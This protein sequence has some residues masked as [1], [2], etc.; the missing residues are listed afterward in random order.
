[1][2]TKSQ[3]NF[4]LMLQIWQCT[5]FVWS[6]FTAKENVNIQQLRDVQTLNM[7]TCIKGNLWFQI[8]KTKPYVW[9]SRKTERVPRVVFGRWGW[10]NEGQQLH[11]RWI[12]KRGGLHHANQLSSPEQRHQNH[13]CD[14]GVPCHQATNSWR[15][16]F[17]MIWEKWTRMAI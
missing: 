4:I 8:Y 13:F 5:F 6:P 17:S 7:T 11:K 15:F 16:A 1:M 3:Y 9:V 14:S 10:R 2:Y 12:A